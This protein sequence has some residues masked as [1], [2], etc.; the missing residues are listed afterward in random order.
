MAI[1]FGRL[2]PVLRIFSIEKAR[3]FY[4]DWLGFKIDWEHKFDDVAPLFMQISRGGLVLFLS[5]HH[6]DGTPG[7]KLYVDMTGVEEFHAEIMGKTY[8]YMR[9][10]LAPT[11]HGTLEFYVIDPFG[12]RIHFS[13]R[14]AR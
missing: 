9:P 8:G 10:D 3:E 5:E 6:G 13:E 2:T 14:R 12:N 1:A 7:T 11:E 4:C